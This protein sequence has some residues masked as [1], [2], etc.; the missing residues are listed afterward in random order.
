MRQTLFFSFFAI[1]TSMLASGAHAQRGIDIDRMTPALDGE[2]FLGIQATVTPGPG[3]WNVGLV[4]SWTTDSLVLRDPMTDDETDIIDHRIAADFQMQIGLGGRFAIGLDVPLL[5]YQ[6]ADGELFG[7]GEG[8]MAATGLGDPRLALRWRFVGDDARVYRERNEGPGLALQGAVTLPIG[9]EAAFVSEAGVTTDLDLIA[10]FHVL[11]AGVGAVLGWKHRFVDREILGVSFED[12]ISLGGAL[13][14]PIP[15]TRDFYAIVEVR[16][17]TD[18]GGFFDRPNTVVEGDFGLRLRR[19]DI[20][21]TAGVGRGFTGGVGSPEFRGL[22]SLHW[23]PRVRDADGDQI[24]DDRDECPFLPEDFDGFEDSDGCLDPDNDN[25]LIPD[26]DDRCPNETAEEFRDEDEDGCTDPMS[27][28]DR[29]GVED[30][31][32]GCPAQPE[33]RDGHQDEDGCPEPDNDG[34]DVLDGQDQCPTEAEDRDGHQDEDGCPDPDNDG[35]GVLDASDAC[36]ND[37]EDRDGFEDEDGCPDVDNDRDGV[38][39]AA[40]TC[41]EGAETING[42]DDADGCPDRGGRT[43]WRATGEPTAADYTLRGRV[44]LTREHA[45][46]PAGTGAIDQLA[47]HLIARWPDRFRVAIAPGADD[48]ASTARTAAIRA[49]LVERGVAEARVD[50]VA[51]PA[52]RGA[53]V[54]VTRAP[55]AQP[56]AEP[57]AAAPEPQSPEPSGAEPAEPGE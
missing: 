46:A 49:A 36:P 7:D 25:D 10:D 16:A 37:A 51:D 23:A 56:L 30:G 15:V 35:D 52:A 53:N 19:D 6:E 41:P 21:V 34:D 24:P 44:Q 47:M 14:L 9:D 4:T 3:R 13:K 57:P 39:D 43:L 11:G 18:T 26:A 27:D 12:E 42:V 31:E 1:T 54:V 5:L 32:D 20:T 28:G 2:G 48:A 55:A 45:V 38:L 40:D 33:D 29:D 50:V 8:T 17:V 22:A